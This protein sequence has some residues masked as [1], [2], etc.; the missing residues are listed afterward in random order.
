MKR[1]LIITILFIVAVVALVILQQPASRSVAVGDSPVMFFVANLK[2][3]LEMSAL[4][5]GRYPT[6]SEGLSALINRPAAIPEGGKWH[7]YLEADKLPNDPR[8]RPY[9]YEIPGKHNPA[10]YD[11]Y[12]LGPNG[13][14]GDEPIGNWT[15]RP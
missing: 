6:R 8:G 3:A 2:T 10:S 7:R 9:V 1:P 13:K 15:S 12:S 14:G 4:D 11:V 5:F